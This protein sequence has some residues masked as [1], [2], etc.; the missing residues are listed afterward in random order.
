[1]TQLCDTFYG[2]AHWTW[3]ILSKARAI[4][5]QIGEETITDLHCLEFKLRHPNQVYTKTF[6]KREEG[7]NGADW[8]WWFTDKRKWLGFR[9]QAKVVDFETDN[10][11]NLHYKNQGQYQ[12]DRL[13]HRSLTGPYKKIPIYCLY[14]QWSSN[15]KL[16]EQYSGQIFNRVDFGCS[17]MSA[18]S[19][20]YMR[21]IKLKSDLESLLHHLQPWV[22]LVCPFHDLKMNLPQQVWWS[23][24]TLV[25]MR[26]SI[27]KDGLEGRSLPP[28]L[29]ELNK[30]CSNIQPTQDP[31][32]YVQQ[33]LNGGSIEQPDAD[34]RTI[35]IFS[36]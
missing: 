10:F 32:P 7:E 5:S 31:P 36:E 17:I 6:S 25:V 26:E 22:G 16:P 27:L 1:M 30:Q 19:V 23:W 28:E 33:V 2:R 3:D 13:L 18:F 24:M 29:V 11:R 12:V 34:L 14:M 4:N 21:E 8:E 9:V 35:T 20:R 15:K